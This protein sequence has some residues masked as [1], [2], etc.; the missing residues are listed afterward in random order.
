VAELRVL[1]NDDAC[2]Q[3]ARTSQHG[4]TP[5]TRERPARAGPRTEARVLELR[6]AGA[7]EDLL[8]VQHPCAHARAA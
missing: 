8:Y 6:P 2:A 4:A 7:A 1:R 3:P 5:T